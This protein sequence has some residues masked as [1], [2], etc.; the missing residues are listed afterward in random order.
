MASA[1]SA[2][3]FSLADAIEDDAGDA[4]R[5]IVR[6]EAPHDGRRRLRLPRYVEHQHDRKPEMRGKIGSR[7]ALRPGDAAGAVEQAHHAFDDENIRVVGRSR[8]QGVE[9][10]GAAWPRSRD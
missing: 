9:Q 2:R 1:T 3:C 10:R 5:G 4:H 7:A 6:G 8:R